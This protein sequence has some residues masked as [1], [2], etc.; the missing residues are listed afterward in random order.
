MPNPHPF[1][2]HFPIALFFTA[3]VC[4]LLA[5]FFRSKPLDTAALVAGIGAAAAAMG[6]VV[7][8]L[9]AEPLVPKVGPA[10]D[11]FESHETL[12]YI[13]LA[14]TIA[15]AGLKMVA[16]VQKTDKYLMAQITIGI[17]G[18]IITLMAAHEGGELVYQHGVGVNKNPPQKIIRVYP[19]ASDSS[20]GVK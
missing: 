1:I 12:G 2:V 16:R 8:G 5:Y 19:P 11:V 14:T 6:A 3:V 20:R 9:L 7:T 15:F 17:I 10:R 13:V 4:E 18:V